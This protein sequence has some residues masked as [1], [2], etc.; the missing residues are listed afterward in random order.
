MCLLN[1]NNQIFAMCY[2][3]STGNETTMT[4]QSAIG[5][6]DKDS[7]GVSSSESSDSTVSSA[8]Q[9]QKVCG[10]HWDLVLIL[11]DTTVNNIACS[12]DCNWVYIHFLAGISQWNSD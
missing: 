6:T 4:L 11:S 8:R 3:A 9:K 12:V 7:D 5:K 1:D 10:W 2:Q